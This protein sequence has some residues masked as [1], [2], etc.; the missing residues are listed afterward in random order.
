MV[1]ISSLH[2][3]AQASLLKGPLAEYV[4]EY[5]ARLKLGRYATN[6][7][8]LR[9]GAIAHFAHWMSSCSLHA[10]QL[11]EGCIDQFFRYHLPR[12][13]C[14]NEAVRTPR[15]LRAA[16][17][18]LLAQLRQQHVIKQLASASGPI[19]DELRRYD[20][21]MRDAQ[22]LASGTRQDRLSIVQR[23]L[24]SKFAGREV[25]IGELRPEDIRCFIGEERKLLGTTSH[26][27]TLAWAL[28][29]YLRYRASFGDTVQPL[30]AA[31]ST[32]ACWGQTSLPKGLTAAEVERLLGSF[33]DAQPSPKRGYAIVRLALD[34]GLRGGEIA[35]LQLADIDWRQGTL[36]LKHTKSGRQEVMPLPSMT[37]RALETYLRK[38]RPKTSN[39]ALFVR[40]IAPYD[41]PIGVD[42]IRRVVRNA[43]R[44]IGIQHGRMHALRHTLACKLVNRGSSI[45]E[46]ADVLRH[47]S[48]NTSLIYAKV[49]YQALFEVALP[50]PGSAA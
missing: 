46:I 26:A 4:D 15:D 13:D 12:C 35:Q 37:G 48:L 24:Q 30:L 10:N 14:Q 42:G 1:N 16:L 47:S 43:F 40:H 44:R 5:A 20:A 33:T 25:L 32:P 29:A 45:K 8:S 7:V 28:R 22:G 38:E 19:A 2:R 11:D 36:T 27:G 3:H 49:D 21:H 39:H 31:I 23:F 17:L 34:L 41:Q 9:L 6:T 18:A 50:W